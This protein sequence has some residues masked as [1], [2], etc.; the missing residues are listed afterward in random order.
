MTPSTCELPATPC[1]RPRVNDACGWPTRRGPCGAALDVRVIVGAATMGVRRVSDT[2]GHATRSRGPPPPVPRRRYAR[3]TT[4][5]DTGGSTSAQGQGQQ[6]HDRLL[7]CGQ[8]PTHPCRQAPPFD[9]I[10]SG[11]PR[12]GGRAPQHVKRPGY[13][14]CGEGEDHF[15]AIRIA[16]SSGSLHRSASRSRRCA[17]PGQRTPRAGPGA[18]EMA[19]AE[20]VR[21]AQPR[22]RRQ[23]GVSNVPGAM[24]ITRTPIRA[25]SRASGSVSPTMP[26]L[27]AA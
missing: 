8:A 12:P 3:S 10:A 19:P 22:E 11:P 17:G 18:A 21:R 5:G 9:E 24:V 23:S 14:P 2:P 26:A 7:T 15:G 1:S 20:R 4:N 16:P 25:N 27:E 6:R 13:Y